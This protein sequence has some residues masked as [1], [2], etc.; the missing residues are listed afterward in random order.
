MI[1]MYGIT[2][3]T[4]HVTF[5]ELDED[6]TAKA[7]TQLGVT[8]PGLRV[9]VLDERGELCPVGVPGEIY[10]GGSGLTRGYVGHPELTAERFVPDHLGGAPG[11]RLYRSGDLGRWNA[12][13]GL[14]YLGR[15][16]TQVKVRGYRIELGE[17]ESA[18][19]AQP[20]VAECVI[21][22]YGGREPREL[23][24]YLVPRRAAPS[25]TYLRSS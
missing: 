6:R 10:V 3:T 7:L 2:E 20:S 9:H 14:E 17:V 25:T 12:D 15:S 11:G 23:A 24:A 1:N 8:L 21:V 13:G 18:L 4:V 22:A 5:G 19:A 16:D